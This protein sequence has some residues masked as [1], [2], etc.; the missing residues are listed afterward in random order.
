[1]PLSATEIWSEKETT[2]E[3]QGWGATRYYS[4]IGTTT[5]LLD[6]AAVVRCPGVPALGESHPNFRDLRVVNKSAGP[7]L[8]ER[9]VS[10]RY[11]WMPEGWSE[12]TGNDDPLARPVVVQWGQGR[13]SEPRSWDIYGNPIANSAGDVFDE[14]PNVDR[15]V[16]TLRITRWERSFNLFLVNGY[17]NKI[18]SA[19]M[20]AG[21]YTFAPGQVLCTFIG[22]AA[23]FEA[24][25]QSIQMAYEFEI[26]SI[27]AAASGNDLPELVRANPF[28]WWTVDRGTRS[29]YDGGGSKIGDL[30]YADDR[31]EKVSDA[32]NLNGQGAPYVAADY[33]V[34]SSGDAPANRTT[35]FPQLVSRV[36]FKSQGCW[37]LG[38]DLFRAANLLD[39]GL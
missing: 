18:N 2:Q 38:F 21:P 28:K 27:S 6:E 5:E 12:N 8:A 13:I 32:V 11:Q 37:L 3:Q 17:V 7:G 36:E 30:Y 10:V 29:F 19:A 15:L 31:T 24:G 25:A 1:M 34:T 39:L 4:V 22:P 23:E 9:K 16:L 26:R 20:P 14:L 35:Y 33:V